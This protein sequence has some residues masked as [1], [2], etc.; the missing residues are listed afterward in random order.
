[1]IPALMMFAEIM[2]FVSR[3]IAQ[4]DLATL[5]EVGAGFSGSAIES[6]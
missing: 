4:I 5:A 3:N 6:D 2:E 1:M